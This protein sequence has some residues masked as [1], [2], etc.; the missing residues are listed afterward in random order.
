MLERAAWNHSTGAELKQ[1]H[2]VAELDC[3]VMVSA[4]REHARAD[5]LRDRA[6]PTFAT[7]ECDVA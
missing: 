5:D 4:C 6:R 3:Y 7:T 2:P 1:D